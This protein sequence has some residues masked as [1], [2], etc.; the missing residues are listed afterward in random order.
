MKILIAI[1]AYNE[2]SVIGE[3]ICSL[4]KKFKNILVVDNNSEDKTLLISKNYGIPVISHSSNIGKSNSM[5]T[6]F[7]Y[8]ILKNFDYVLFM[9]GD[10]QHKIEDVEKLTNHV[11]KNK[12]DLLIGYRKN[13]SNLNFKKKIGTL[14]L[15]KVFFI[16]FKKKIIDIQSGL[17]ILNVKSKNKFW[18]NSRGISHYFA[19]AEISALSVKNNCI[20]D[21]I[22]IL[23]IRSESYKGM[24]IVQGLYLLIM[25]FVWKFTR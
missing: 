6:A 10:G 17:R 24:N 13:L 5:K 23:T 21:Q 3:V 20:I 16:L 9:D 25:L 22:P 15:K 1:F 7:E 14:V 12:V 19:D 8:A 11:K 4:K 2:E 18:W